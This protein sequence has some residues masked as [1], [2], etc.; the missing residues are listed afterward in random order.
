MPKNK[1]RLVD[2]ATRQG[3]GVPHACM[4]HACFTCRAKVGAAKWTRTSASRWRT[5]ASAGSCCAVR[6]AP[7]HTSG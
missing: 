4:G 7:P 5:T 6:A 2:V 3:L 1:E